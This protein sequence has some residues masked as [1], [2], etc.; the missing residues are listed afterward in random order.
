MTDHT[1]GNIQAVAAWHDE[2]ASSAYRKRAF[3]VS[4][5]H[6]YIA[7]KLRRTHKMPSEF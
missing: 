6:A 4:R 5:R 1:W 2:R 3:S 7:A